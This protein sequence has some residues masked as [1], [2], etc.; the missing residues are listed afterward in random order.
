[1]DSHE[2]VMK[3]TRFGPVIVPGDPLSSSLYRLVAGKVDASIRMPH[4]K[5][6]LSDKEIEAVESWI[7]QGA[8][9]D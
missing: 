7:A 2:L 9:N 6:K 5:E 8:K 3:G 1:V 4:G